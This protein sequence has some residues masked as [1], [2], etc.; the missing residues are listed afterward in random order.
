MTARKSHDEDTI[1]NRAQLVDHMN[2]ENEIKRAEKEA[3]AA[4]KAAVAE[5]KAAESK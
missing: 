3:A 5:A 1:D 4:E 2:A